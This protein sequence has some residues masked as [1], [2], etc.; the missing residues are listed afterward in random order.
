MPDMNAWVF[1]VS[2]LIPLV[3]GSIWYN[4]KVFGNTWL[5]SSGLSSEEAASGNMA[6][7][8][9]LSYVFALLMSLVLYGFV[10]HQSAVNSLM[11]TEVDLDVAG[12]DA[13]LFYSEVMDRLG[14]KHRSFG[15]GALHGTFLGLLFVTP[16]I[17]TISLFER[18]SFK[19]IAVHAG[20]WIISLAL[21]GG[22][23]CQMA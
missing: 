22:L 3:V 13:Q 4:P 17:G 21:M 19:Y 6:L 20:Y 16:L 2:A 9:G 5:K 23:L 14:D 12:S 15:H 18:R 1:F 10:V 11:F 7:I 8:F